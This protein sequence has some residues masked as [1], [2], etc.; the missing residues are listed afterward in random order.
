MKVLIYGINYA[1][2]LTGIGKYTAETAESLAAD[3]HQVRVIC[4]P[5]YYPQWQVGAGFSSW[6]YSRQVM[7]GVPVWRAPLWIPRKPSAL[8]RIV[9][10][11]SFA[12]ASFP[13]LLRQAFWRPE[14][15][16]CIAPSLLNAPA[17]W[18]LA[19]ST[20]AHAW[21]HI[22]DYEIDAAFKLDMLSGSL[23]KRAALALERGLLTRFD[24]VSTIS[25]KMI[26]H[27]LAK[28]VE[29][30]R[31]VSFPNWADT[32]AIFPLRRPSRLR[33][34]LK[35]PAGAIVVLYSGNMGQKQGLEILGAA[36]AQLAASPN[37][38]FVFCGN[39]PARATLDALC[40][41]LP[42][43]RFIDLQPQA[44]LNDLLNLADIHVLP[45]RADAADLVM[46]S[47]LTGMFAS[48]RAVIA[49]ANPGTELF[50]VVAPRGVVVAPGEADA[51]AAAIT[52]LAGDAE[53]RARLGAAGRQFAR[54]VLSRAVVL[55]DF[56]ATLAARCA[57]DLPVAAATTAALEIARAVAQARASARLSPAPGLASK[58]EAAVPTAPEPCLLQE[59]ENRPGLPSRQA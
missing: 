23:F 6:R 46:P 58:P 21:L 16:L 57:K 2:E 39:G 10:L 22:Q 3:G 44:R 49:M 11:A 34:K 31:L 28:G 37:L 12:L 40:G 50:N 43:C 7:D 59:D 55:R 38:V 19:R 20:G 53:E 5:P 9:H 54:A 26:E 51:L 8:T 45:Q 18:L 35:I 27:A 1:P 33:I 15:V 42:H 32:E 30:A 25:S 13:L 36:A 24:T 52:K 41:K 48:G 17:G 4:A 14:V 29:P 56:E 47:K